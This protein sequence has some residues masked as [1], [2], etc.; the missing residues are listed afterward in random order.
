MAAQARPSRALGALQRLTNFW[1][2]RID[3]FEV[4]GQDQWRRLREQGIADER[5]SLVRDGSPITFSEGGCEAL[6]ARAQGQVRVLLRKFR[7]SPRTGNSGVGLSTA[8]PFRFGQV[9]LWINATGMGAG[10]LSDRL[11]GS[12]VPFFRCM[13]VP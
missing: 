13:P 8:P 12:S 7:R 6:A 2:R 4:L 1:R 11:T 9:H 3:A 10:L 5:I